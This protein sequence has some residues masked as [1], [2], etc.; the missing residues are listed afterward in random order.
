MLKSWISNKNYAKH[1]AML[2]L[3]SNDSNK[4]FLRG[5]SNVIMTL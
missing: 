2:V 5:R 1:C 3:S 4:Y